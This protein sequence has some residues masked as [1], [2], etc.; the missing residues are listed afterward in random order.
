VAPKREKTLSYRR[1][2]WLTGIPKGTT[3]ESC[4][5]DAHNA[6]K[7]VDERTIVRDN[8]Q[9]IRSANKLAQRDGGFFLHLT[10][11]A[12]GAN[13]A[14]DDPAPQ[15]FMKKGS[16]QRRARMKGQG[17]YQSR[18]A[19]DAGKADD[20]E[21][22][23]CG[24][25]CCRDCRHDDGHQHITRIFYGR[26]ASILPTPRSAPGCEA[27]PTHPWCRFRPVPLSFYRAT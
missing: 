17:K 2:E 16:P 24:G 7:T 26:R 11:D 23:P 14:G 21:D 18:L 9:R 8:G 20:I 3:L 19:K 22:K 27:V 5:R 12:P 10:L 25:D 13:G 4:L 1:A 15:S 6:L